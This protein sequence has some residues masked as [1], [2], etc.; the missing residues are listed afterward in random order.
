MTCRLHHPR[1]V[2]QVRRHLKLKRKAFPPSYVYDKDVVGITCECALAP[3]CQE[4]PA[5]MSTS[6]KAE[7]LLIIIC[8]E[9]YVKPLIPPIRGECDFDPGEEQFI[10][11]SCEVIKDINDCIFSVHKQRRES[12]AL[13]HDRVAKDL[14]RILV[15]TPSLTSGF[16]LD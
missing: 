5:I 11:A 6:G 2:S 4:L 15:D 16:N 3:H 13:H 7:D 12:E 9:A 14:I 1:C 10:I 8:S